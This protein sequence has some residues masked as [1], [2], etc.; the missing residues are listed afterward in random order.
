MKLT[1]TKIIADSDVKY[2]SSARWRQELKRHDVFV[3]IDK[4]LLELLRHGMMRIEEI[5]LL[6]FDE[7]HHTEGLSDYALIMKEF[8]FQYF[9]FSLSL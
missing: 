3:I 6:V 7:C 9:S 1:K 8:Y 4:I 2:M 5:S